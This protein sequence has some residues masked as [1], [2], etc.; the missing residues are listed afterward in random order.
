MKI[1]NYIDFTPRLSNK[2]AISISQK[3]YGMDVLASPL[4]SERDQNFLLK[5]KNTGHKYVLKISNQKEREEILDLQNS[6]MERVSSCLGPF[7]CPKICLTKEGEKIKKIIHK[8]Q[9]SHYVRMVTYIEGVVL[10]EAHPHTPDLLQSVGEFIAKIELALK[11]FSHP[12]ARR[13]FYWDLQRG[14][15]TIKKFMKYIDNSYEYSLIKYFLGKFQSQAAGIV[16]ELEKT[17]IHNDGN[18]Y[19]IL[20]SFPDKSRPNQRKASGI[21]DFG[22]MVYSYTVGDI[23][24]AAAYVMLDK[25]NYWD[26]A[27]DLIKGYDEVIKISDKE[28]EAISHFIYL[29]LCM[30]VAISAFQKK[31]HP[32]NEYLV[33]SEKNAWNLLKKMKETKINP[34]HLIKKI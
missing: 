17:V 3:L 20:V 33:I 8:N 26:S 1:T 12:A 18:D 25:E 10:A 24:V 7:S 13:R 11:D 9:S 34:S 32:D 19:N 6:A 4:P 16:S 15:E 31:Q 14:P 30:S 27:S 23:A 5:E 29:R 22:D 28:L 2:E 21:I